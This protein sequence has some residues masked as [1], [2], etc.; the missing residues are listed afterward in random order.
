MGE[1]DSAVAAVDALDDAV[2]N[3]GGCARALSLEAALDGSE[4]C[5]MAAQVLDQAADDVR[6]VSRWLLADASEGDA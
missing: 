6:R 3:I 2:V 1:I 5:A 4:I